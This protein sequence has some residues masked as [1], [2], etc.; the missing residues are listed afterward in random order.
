[1]T[2]ALSIMRAEAEVA[3]WRN[4]HGGRA[5]FCCSVRALLYCEMLLWPGWTSLAL[6]EIIVTGL[7][8][9]HFCPGWGEGHCPPPPPEKGGKFFPGGGGMPPPP[10]EKNPGGGH[11]KTPKN[12]YLGGGGGLGSFLALFSASAK[13]LFLRL[14]AVQ[15]RSKT[16]AENFES[17]QK[18]CFFC[19]FSSPQ[20]KLFFKTP[21]WVLLK[22]QKN[23]GG[24]QAKI[25]GEGGATKTGGPPE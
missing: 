18:R 6:L 16:A 15:K 7:S 25:P 20:A 13:K 14:I 21:F 12:G 22:K 17:V 19:V 4:F 2:S 10:R 9:D 23:S 3:K 24:G 8:L 1:M 11:P 5:Q